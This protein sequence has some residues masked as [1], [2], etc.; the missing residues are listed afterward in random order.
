[1]SR[2]DRGYGDDRSRAPAAEVGGVT[3]NHALPTLVVIGAMKCG[4]TALH[5]LLDV[6]PDVSMSVPKELN[7]FFG[8]DPDSAAPRTGGRRTTWA[9]GNWHRGV[10]WYRRHFPAEVPVRG[11]SSPGYTSPDH[12]EVAARM[13]HVVPDVRLVY[14]VRD[15]IARAVSQY[16]H[17]RRDGSEHRPL[18][19]AVLDPASQYVARS[20]YHERLVPFLAAFRVERIHLVVQEELL[21]APERTLPAVF[22]F[23]GAD[24]D[25]WSPRFRR[26]SPS[27]SSTVALDLDVRRRLHALLRDDVERLALLAGRR[28]PRWSL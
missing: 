4:T 23:A 13:V 25:F 14:L 27:A 7:F 17:H 6:H 16:R 1:M 5:R 11:E 3:D 8:P 2:S 24:P 21:A 15:P 9:D 26:P 19:T 22:G 20:R 28:F 18:E 12:P 10:D